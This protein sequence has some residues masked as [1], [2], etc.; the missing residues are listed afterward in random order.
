[1]ELVKVLWRLPPEGRYKINVH[2][3]YSEIPLPNG[4]MT[5]IG[6]VIRNHRG[7]IMCMLAGSL[8][9]EDRRL[10]ELY[11]LLEGLKRAYLDDKFDVIVESDH[12]DSVWEWRTAETNRVVPIH[13][14]VI[15][16]LQQRKADINFRISERI[17]DVN[18]N[19][20]AAY[21][22]RYV[23]ENFSRM[24]ILAGPVGRVFELWCNDMGL[25]PIRDQFMA[26]HEMD[27]LADVVQEGAQEEVN[28]QAGGVVAEDAMEALVDEEMMAQEML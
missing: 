18:A 21:L 5:G 27:L 24:V 23:A 15:Q 22:A 12:E 28:V 4:N 1:M 7:R 3:F 26:V 14:Y 19:N 8:V 20:L 16:Q 11:A 17:I 13:R 6:V 10:N 25:G 2:S 9:I